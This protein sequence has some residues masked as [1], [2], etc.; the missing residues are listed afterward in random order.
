[1]AT[2]V[3]LHVLHGRAAKKLR[4][5]QESEARNERWRSL[6]PEQQ[7]AELDLRFGVGQ[8]AGRQRKRL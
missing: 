5:H 6:S 1:M 3:G 7:L 2:T 8:G 4:K